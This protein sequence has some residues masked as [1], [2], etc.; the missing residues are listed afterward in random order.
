MIA[1]VLLVPDQRDP[2]GL[3]LG[4]PC[5]AMPPAAVTS[6]FDRRA[7]AAQDGKWHSCT[8]PG[9]RIRGRCAL[10]LAWDGKRLKVA[11]PWLRRAFDAGLCNTIEAFVDGA[12]R[13]DMKCARML[14]P[15]AERREMRFVFVDATGR[16]AAP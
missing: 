14:L 16:E 8:K 7:G 4:G 11:R 3:L 1:G 15:Y 10:S 13:G 5:G 6:Q 9:T 12:I 2:A